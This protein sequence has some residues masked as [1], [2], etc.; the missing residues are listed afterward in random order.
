MTY[1]Q[2]LLQ[3]LQEEAAE[4]IAAASK[5]QRF[6][7][8]EVWPNAAKN[9]GNL[10]NLQRLRAELIDL[11]ALVEMLERSSPEAVMFPTGML[12]LEV[13]HEKHAKMDKVRHYLIYSQKVGTLTP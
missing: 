11:A 9:P 4:V 13:L 7:L 3:I 1:Q 10:S 8:P 5:C 12:T 6:T 2:H